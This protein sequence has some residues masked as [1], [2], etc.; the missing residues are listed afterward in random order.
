M[1]RTT[2]NTNTRRQSKRLLDRLA[3]LDKKQNEERICRKCL[4]CQLLSQTDRKPRRSQETAEKPQE[5]CH[6]YG[7]LIHIPG[8]PTVDQMEKMQTFAYKFMGSPIAPLHYIPRL[9]FADLTM[10]EKDVG[11]YL[12]SDVG[13]DRL[14]NIFSNT[15]QPRPPQCV[16][17]AAAQAEWKL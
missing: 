5:E 14:V 17:D 1:A 15:P 6:P 2:T 7:T 16:L 8:V 9:L 12:H 4:G 13:M 11:S 10:A 3:K